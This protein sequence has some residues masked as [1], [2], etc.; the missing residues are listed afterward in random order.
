[1]IY[2]F[3]KEKLEIKELLQGCSCDLIRASE[4]L[5][6]FKGR[7]KPIHFAEFIARDH[8]YADV[9]CNGKMNATLRASHGHLVMKTEHSIK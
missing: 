3:F 9:Q 1:M 8:F 7:G 5:Q 6:P 2:D 4:S